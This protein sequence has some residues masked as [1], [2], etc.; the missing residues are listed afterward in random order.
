MKWLEEN[1][2]QFFDFSWRDT[3][4]RKTKEKL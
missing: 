4:Y 2:L 3:Q 1:Y